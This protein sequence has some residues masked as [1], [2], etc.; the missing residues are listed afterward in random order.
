MGALNFKS[1]S[2]DPQK[3]RAEAALQQPERWGGLCF[4]DHSVVSHGGVRIQCEVRDAQASSRG[5][6]SVCP[7]ACC[8][9]QP[10]MRV[11]LLVS[12]IPAQVL[13]PYC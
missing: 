13:Q 2:G 10:G 11:L 6:S 12:L 8:A 4:R 9:R 1:S 7:L 5:G 3:D